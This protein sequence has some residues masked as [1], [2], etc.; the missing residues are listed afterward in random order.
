MILSIGVPTYNRGE[1]LK[2]CLNNIAS[3]I[4]KDL[5]NKVSITIADNSSTDNTSDVVSEIIK[6][7]ND[8]EIIYYKHQTNLGYDQNV[9]SLFH[10]S[11]SDYVMPL[12]DDDGLEDNA[13]KEIVEHL[14]ENKGVSV[15]YISNNY[16][17]YNLL[18]KVP[19]IDPFFKKIG[20]NK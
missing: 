17:D 11:E 4:T 9:N 1:M 12:S 2:D 7:Y 20:A 5:Q 19:I 14:E 6:K 18:E 15:F 3:Q 10:S 16:Y 13:I 8:I